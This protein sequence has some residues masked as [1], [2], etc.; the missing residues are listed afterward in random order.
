MRRHR[1]DP[2]YTDRD[3]R[4]WRR[5]VKTVRVAMRAPLA[6]STPLHKAAKACCKAVPPTG[7]AIRGSSFLDLILKAQAFGHPLREAKA[8]EL[9]RLADGVEAILDQAGAPPVLRSRVDLDG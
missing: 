1:P 4:L 7:H 2:R 9:G 8:A 3:A 6:D 5:L